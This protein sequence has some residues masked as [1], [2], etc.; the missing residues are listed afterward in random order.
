M[1]KFK[2]TDFQID[3]LE[4]KHFLE[5]NCD[6]PYVSITAECEANAWETYFDK[7]KMHIIIVSEGA[8]KECNNKISL[9]REVL[10]KKALLKSRKELARYN[11]TLVEV[12]PDNVPPKKEYD[13]LINDIKA[14]L[15]PVNCFIPANSFN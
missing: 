11:I 2:N 14:M 6:T 12:H 7:P 13:L 9:A 4:I 5:K 15:G 8:N 10:I 1:K 3:I